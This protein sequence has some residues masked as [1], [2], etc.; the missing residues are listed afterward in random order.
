MSCCCGFGSVLV[1]C[2]SGK[3]PP[4]R[5]DSGSRRS[6]REMFFSLSGFGFKDS[7][8]L[9]GDMRVTTVWMSSLCFVLTSVLICSIFGP[10]K[11]M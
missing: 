11:K 5:L 1:V 9:N 6:D 2:G 3:V 8:T 4:S 10:S 7:Q